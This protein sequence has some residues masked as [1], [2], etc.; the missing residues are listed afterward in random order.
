MKKLKSVFPYDFNPLFWYYWKFPRIIVIF[1]DYWDSGNGLHQI[2]DIRKCLLVKHAS[3]LTKLDFH[4]A[5]KLSIESKFPRLVNLCLNNCD[6]GIKHCYFITCDYSVTRS[7]SARQWEGVDSIFGQNYVMAK[8]VKSCTYC[9]YVRC[10]TLIVWVGGNALAPNRHNSEP[11]TD[12]TSRQRLCN[13]GV[14]C[15]Q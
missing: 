13:Q 8:D 3:Q 12:S 4:N 7:A 10:V 9:C 1:Q 15:L 5:Y 6:I 2:E 14:C 11:S